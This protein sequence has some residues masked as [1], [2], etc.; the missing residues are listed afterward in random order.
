M[1]RACKDLDIRPARPVSC[2]RCRVVRG[3]HVARSKSQNASNDAAFFFLV[4]FI[5]LVLVGK[6]ASS[7]EKL[8]I[9]ID[10]SP[11]DFQ[12][13]IHQGVESTSSE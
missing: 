2:R 1:R 12:L 9:D 6:N 7:K 10:I 11:C 4:D 3:H 13:S 8:I 5:D